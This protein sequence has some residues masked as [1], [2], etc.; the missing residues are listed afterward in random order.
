M[1][2]NMTAL[3]NS[4]TALICKGCKASKQTSTATKCK[5]QLNND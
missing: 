2:K 5:A 3:I 4:L 1:S